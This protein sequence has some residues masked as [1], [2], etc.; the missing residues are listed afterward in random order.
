MKKKVRL[1]QKIDRDLMILHKNPAFS[2]NKALVQSLHNCVYRE[3]NYIKIPP[4]VELKEDVPKKMEVI[5]T[6]NDPKINNWILKIPLGRRNDFMKNLL[7]GYLT[8]PILYPY[9]GA[10]EVDPVIDVM[11]DPEKPMMECKKREKEYIEEAGY[12]FEKLKK[13]LGKI[14]K[15]PEELIN[16]LEDNAIKEAVELAK[17]E[18]KKEVKKAKPTVKKEEIKSVET[19]EETP[20]SSGPAFATIDP[21]EVED[22]EDFDFMGALRGLTEEQS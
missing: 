19:P 13:S 6:I 14:G 22:D 21:A 12:E 7:R 8:G 3:V 18:K 10:D 9:Y 11:N 16:L 1:Y 2:L 4:M 20:K 5:V 15:T 17:E